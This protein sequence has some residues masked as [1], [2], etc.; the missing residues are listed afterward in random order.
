MKRDKIYIS[1]QARESD[2]TSLL[3]FA[4]EEK[5]GLELSSGFDTSI[6]NLFEIISKENLNYKFHNYFPRPNEPFVL[7]LGSLNNDVRRKSIDFVKRNM[8]LSKKLNLEYYSCH[9]GFLIDPNPN[10]LGSQ[11]DLSLITKSRYEQSLT[12]FKK[13]IRELITLCETHNIKL[14]IENNVV[15]SNNI[16]NGV[17]VALL[18]NVEEIILFFDEFKNSIGLLFDTAHYKVNCLS[19]N[20]DLSDAKLLSKYCNVVHHSEPIKEQDINMPFNEDY[21]FMEYMYLFSHCDHVLE[22]KNVS[23]N[24]LKNAIYAISK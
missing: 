9:A 11:F 24:E 21:W 19:M 16:Y 1:T 20:L 5:V 18:T 2:I 14:L 8:L 10:D 7:N 23:N 6:N 12:A 4:F 22:F 15:P 13:S 17:P 3:N